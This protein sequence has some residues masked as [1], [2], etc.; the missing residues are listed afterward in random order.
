MIATV[1]PPGNSHVATSPGLAA[2]A[3]VGTSD[4]QE[5]LSLRD[6]EELAR[7]YADRLFSVARRFLHDEEDAADAVQDAFLAAWNARHTFQGESTVYTWL[8]RIVVN[9]CLMKVRARRRATVVSLDELLPTFD[10][11]ECHRHPAVDWSQGA[12]CCL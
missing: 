4:K 2:S 12:A 10:Q 7:D 3:S 1:A 11:D 5:C 8:Y 9:V 6:C